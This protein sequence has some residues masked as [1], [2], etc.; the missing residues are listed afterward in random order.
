MVP[1]TV[2]NFSLTRTTSSSTERSSPRDPALHD[3]RRRIHADRAEADEAGDQ[4]RSRQ[5]LK[6]TFGTLA[7][8]RTSDVDSCE[9]AVLHQPERTTT[10]SIT[11]TITIPAFGYCV[12]GKV[13]EGRRSRMRDRGVETDTKRHVPGRPVQPVVIKSVKLVSPGK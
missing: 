11:K 1:K 2:D 8:A 13:I 6:N 7:M 12:F 4:E 3:P 5:C 10:S 9:R